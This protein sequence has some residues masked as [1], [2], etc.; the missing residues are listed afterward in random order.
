MT[1]LKNKL[2]LTILLCSI[3]IVLTK[4][5]KVD[6][7][8]LATFTAKYPEDQAIFLK[9]YE[10][11]DIKISGD[12]LV[13]SSKHLKETLHLGNKSNVYA[14]DGIYSSS[15]YQNQSI[16]ART[17][18][19]EKR[20]FKV[21]KVTEFK[22]S[23]DKSS[24]VFYDDG[25]SINF[26][27]PAVQP[28]AHTILEY[29]QKIKD[30]KFI[31]SFLF[32][33]YL[34][35]V[36]SKFTV[37]VDKGVD[38]RLDIINNEDNLVQKKTEDLSNRI[39]YTFECNNADKLKIED[40]AP[41]IRFTA[42]HIAA[43]V[44]KFEANG[45]THQVL[46]S[47]DDLFSW[48]ST[49][50]KGLKSGN[51]ENI[52]KVLNEIIDPNDEELEKVKKIFHWVQN[53]VK[54][55]AF[56]DGMRGLIPHN[57]EYVCDKRYGDCKDMASITVNML[58]EAGIDAH[59]TWIGTRDI[60][61]KYSEYPS[62]MV[63][64]HMIATYINDG[65]YYYLD[66]TSQY[67]S[68][69]LPSSMIQGKEALIALD[70]NNYEIQTVPVIDKS[71]NVK[72][73]SSFY[74]LKDGSIVGLGK[75]T[76]SGFPKV[77]NSYNMIKSS[78]KGLDDFM[79]QFMGR[80]NNKFFLDDYQ[81]ANLDDL[82]QPIEVNYKFRVEDYYR[83]IGSKI[84]FNMN[85]VKSLTDKIIDDERKQPIENEFNYIHKNTSVLQIP[86]NYV[87]KHLP[88]NV[89]YKNEVF[90]FDI[91]YIQQGDKIILNK[92]L[93]VD[94]LLLEKNQFELWNEGIKKLSDSYRDA[95]I[96]EN[97]GA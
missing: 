81:I 2:I 55:I 85:L 39:K 51:Y 76:I 70:E 49:F 37:T 52:K 62:P 18:I 66:A 38:I 75:M 33:N 1:F 16:S 45:S 57:A 86:E 30:P 35:I 93:Y 78:K 31:G 50:I 44:Q 14:K 11:I 42:P 84:Y 95:L 7:D 41:P 10:D 34:P 87:V 12:S 5:Q 21:I 47:A 56:E 96:L 15:F 63:D 24:S 60:P 36:H 82:E 8:E 79:T 40:D 72:N 19:P 46:S 68:Y 26:I 94:Y 29:E 71:L 90:G 28:G 48:Y 23:F 89:S 80:G 17:L 73:D 97:E 58:N 92:Q 83:K 25:K 67:S 32:Q 4:A 88:E 65:K 53:N 3:S 59:F 64:N 20:K 13:V 22:E 91:Q 74:S 54:Y 9:Y 77:F 27:F 6:P 69:K 61:Y 43:I